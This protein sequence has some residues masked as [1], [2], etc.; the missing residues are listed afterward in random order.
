M[1]WFVS[2]GSWIPHEVTTLRQ[3]TDQERAKLI[4]V[5]IDERY[6]ASGHDDSNFAQLK[7]AGF[8]EKPIQFDDLLRGRLPLE[9]TVVAYTETVQKALQKADYVFATLGLGADGHTAGI[10]PQSP[11][12]TD[13]SSVVIGYRADDFVRMTCGLRVLSAIDEVHVFAYGEQKQA[14][15][16]RLAKGQ[17]SSESLPSMLLYGVPHVTIYSDATMKEVSI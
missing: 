14:A 8:L 5:L 9:K 4:V 11:A 16:A 15:V 17:E 7:A 1:L 3:L 10:L 13:I 12:A 6:G 2:G